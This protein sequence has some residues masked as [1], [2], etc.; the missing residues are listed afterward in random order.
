MG[1]YI[2][3]FVGTSS[4][5]L[6]PSLSK[7]SLVIALNLARTS[8][9]AGPPGANRSSQSSIVSWHHRP[10]SIVVGRVEKQLFRCRTCCRAV[11]VA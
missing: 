10:G 8:A 1:A 9:E 11:R 7:V 6:M 3:V 4:K 2:F 5:G